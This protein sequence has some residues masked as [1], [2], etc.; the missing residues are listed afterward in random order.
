MTASATQPHVGALLRTWR[1]RRRLSQL[2]LSSRTGVSTRHL[3]FLE[4]GRAKPTRGMLLRLA[5]EMEVPLR[6]RNELLLSAGFAPAYAE[7]PLG[8]PAMAPVREAL[9][10][11]LAGYEP[12]PAVVIDRSWHLVA[13]NRSVSLLTAGVDRALLTPPTNVLRLSLHPDGMAPRIANLAQWRTHLLHRLARD[14]AISGDPGLA[15]LHQELVALPG[16]RAPTPVDGIAVPLRLRHED[17]EL[18]FLSTVTTFGTAVDITTAELST[19]AF[20]PADRHTA[21]VLRSLIDV[22]V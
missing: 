21:T 17:G 2:D 13:A 4:T 20:L 12:Y 16:G 18:A 15:A 9:D 11:V 1:Q 5:E 22:G 3:S 10:L 19:E 7:R 14:A 6:A 8:D